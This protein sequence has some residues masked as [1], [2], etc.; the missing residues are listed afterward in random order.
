MVKGENGY[1][2]VTSID[3]DYDNY[4]DELVEVFL[5]GKITKE[6]TFEE[7]RHNAKLPVFEFEL[8]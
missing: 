8:S 4:D 6:Y 5:N 7:V 2:T 1:F 3:S